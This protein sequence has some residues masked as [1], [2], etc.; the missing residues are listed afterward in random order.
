MSAHV[1][2]PVL[3]C[4]TASASAERFFFA[5]V[6]ARAHAWSVCCVV[7]CCVVLCCVV[8][9]CVVLCCVVL[10]CVVLCCVVLCC[11]VLCLFV[12]MF[13][14][15]VWVG[16]VGAAG[17]RV[18]PVLLADM[19]MTAISVCQPE[20]PQQFDGMGFT[21]ASCQQVAD[22][23]PTDPLPDSRA[24]R[25]A[26][27]VCVCVHA[28]VLQY[29]FPVCRLAWSWQTICVLDMP[30]HR[31]PQLLSAPSSCIAIRSHSTFMSDKR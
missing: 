21:A 31:N 20:A 3:P 8:L 19:N 10:C 27:F 23:E 28:H 26:H 7:L 25:D 1:S 18:H 2:C 5:R 24:G 22:S 13:V 9:C 17:V 30:N 15:C 29:S 4:L 6:R 16:V 12:C 14:L 11:V